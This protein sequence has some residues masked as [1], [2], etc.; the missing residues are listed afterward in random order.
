MMEP[1]LDLPERLREDLKALHQPQGRV[2]AELDEAILAAAPTRQT[3]T[4]RPFLVRAASLAA[5]AVLL[6][7][8]LVFVALWLRS[9]R[10]EDP[11]DVDVARAEDVDGSGRVDILD[12]LALARRVENGAIEVRANAAL[13][14][15]LDFDGDGRIDQRDVQHVAREAVR[16][17]A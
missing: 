11:V 15:G 13:D 9:Q 1:E 3:S 12:A 7:V 16:I 8:P 2:P 6:V 5:A 17:D 14:V 10:A 4:R